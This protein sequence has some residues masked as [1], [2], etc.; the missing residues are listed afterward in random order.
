VK[1]LTVSHLADRQTPLH[2]FG[3][4][5]PPHPHFKI[6]K[7]I[8]SSISTTSLKS[9]VS[10]KSRQQWYGLSVQIATTHSQSTPAAPFV[11]QSAI[12]PPTFLPIPNQLCHRE[13]QHPQIVPCRY[14]RSPMKNKQRFER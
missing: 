12:T 7:A 9:I 6:N 11:A 4:T 13:R 2:L 3:F 14:G 8:F 10:S 1:Y 5:P